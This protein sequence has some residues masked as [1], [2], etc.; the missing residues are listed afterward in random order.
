MSIST[1]T[2]QQPLLSPTSPSVFASQRSQYNQWRYCEFISA[3]FAL[4]GMLAQ[5]AD[6]EERYSAGRN[7]FNCEQAELS[8]YYRWL[9]TLFT[10][11]AVCFQVFRHHTKHMWE[12][13]KAS[14][15]LSSAVNYKAK[16]TFCTAGL[17]IDLSL[18][19][20]YP[21][22]Y[23]NGSVQLPERYFDGLVW[24][25]MELCYTY[26]ELLY[27]LMFGRIYLLLRCVIVH[28]G[29]MDRHARFVSAKHGVKANTFFTL[30]AL[31]RVRPYLMLCLF[32]GPVALVLAA[33]VRVFERPFM[34]CTGLDFEPY[35]NG[36]WLSMMTIT[37]TNYADFYPSTHLGRVVAQGAGIWGLFLISM[38]VIIMSRSF[39]ITWR[40]QGALFHANRTRAAAK[41]VVAALQLNNTHKRGS[42]LWKIRKNALLNCIFSF[43]LTKEHIK[44]LTDETSSDITDLKFVLK[45]LETRQNRVDKQIQLLI[46]RLK[47]HLSRCA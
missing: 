2:L 10:V 43:K 9:C 12:K 47:Q 4:L 33:L 36:L 26:A 41:V 40:Q 13:F 25:D 23:T 34:E 3:G 46:H 24:R 45:K 28:F 39:T 1:S 5:V 32:C 8:Q 29:L 35:Y 14:K 19:C 11:V 6:Y 20:I 27:V 44:S 22:P 16:Q 30:R 38:M 18:L 7:V 42:D 37:T 15:R 31:V 21:Y 17:L